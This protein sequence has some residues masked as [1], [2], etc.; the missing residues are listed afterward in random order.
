MKRVFWL[1]G[2]VFFLMGCSPENRELNQAMM[3]RDKVLNAQKCSFSAEVTAD[4]G[5]SLFSFS[6][7][8]QADKKGNLEFVITK[9]DT[10]AGIEG[11]ITDSGGEVVF[12]NTA[13]YF[14]MLTD[15]HLTPASAPWIFLKTLRSGYISSVCREDVFLH[16]TVDDSYSDGEL[17]LDIWLDEAGTPIRG[18]VLYD[19]KRILSLKVENLVFL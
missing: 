17:K 5:D 19:G 7:D 12:D 15:E 4:Y 13:L 18:D 11:H 10:I 1:M 2:L 14:P 8:C 16:I 3:L 6:M 9:P